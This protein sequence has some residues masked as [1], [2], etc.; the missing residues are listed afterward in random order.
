VPALFRRLAAALLL[1]RISAD[2]ARIAG[3]L[4]A[5]TQLL[6]RLADRYAPQLAPLSPADR[7]I[8][9]ADTGVTHLDPVE[10]ALALDFIS[11]QQAHTGHTPDDEEI[12]IHLA[13]E[14]T[15]DLAARLTA[16][17]DELARLMEER[18]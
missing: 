1:R 8:V 3:T 18:R 15:H 5:Q 14:K 7:S 6:A 17:D 12:L 10:A 13:D 9:R 16:R 4:D 11:R 2:L